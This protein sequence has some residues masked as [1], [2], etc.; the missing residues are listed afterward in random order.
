MERT[1]N[2]KPFQSSLEELSDDEE[3]DSEEYSDEVQSINNKQCRKSNE[4]S[5][6]QT[7]FKMKLEKAKGVRKNDILQEKEITD[8]YQFVEKIGKGA[9]GKVYRAKHKESGKEYAIKCIFEKGNINR[10]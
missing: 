1:A 9:Y 5:L 3:E 8:F 2:D 7:L 10:R 4:K 6:K